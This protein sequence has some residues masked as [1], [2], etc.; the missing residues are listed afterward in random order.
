MDDAFEIDRQLVVHPLLGDRAE[1]FARLDAGIDEQ[2][3]HPALRSADQAIGAIKVQR[4]GHV[5]LDGDGI[6]AD[7]G[8]RF[9][10]YGLAAPQ[11]ENRRAFGRHPLR[12]GQ[13]DA[14]TTAGDHSHLALQ[15]HTHRS[16]LK[17]INCYICRRRQAG[18]SFI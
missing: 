8:N 2:D 1:R 5:G 12:R 3:V 16:L 18:K 4:P 7:P 11:D 9:I 17:Y 6:T 13:P 15:G 10:Q 14:F